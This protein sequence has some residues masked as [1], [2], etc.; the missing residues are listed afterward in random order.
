MMNVAARKV[1]AIASKKATT[2]RKFSALLEVTEE[3]PG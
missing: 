1:L 2:A 3:Y